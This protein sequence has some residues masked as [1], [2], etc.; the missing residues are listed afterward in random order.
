MCVFVFCFLPIDNNLTWADVLNQ[1]AKLTIGQGIDAIEV[2]YSTDGAEETSYEWYGTLNIISRGNVLATDS[3]MQL[4]I[5]GA[6][7]QIPSNELV[8]FYSAGFNRLD[9]VAHY[10]MAQN[11]QQFTIVDVLETYDILARSTFSQDIVLEELDSVHKETV[12]QSIMSFSLSYG[13]ASIESIYDL[14]T[15]DIDA[16]LQDAL[17]VSHLRMLSQ[18]TRSIPTVLSLYSES[19]KFYSHKINEIL[20]NPKSTEL[21]I[22]ESFANLHHSRNKVFEHKNDKFFIF[23]RPGNP[24]NYFYQIYWQHQGH[25]YLFFEVQESSKGVAVIR[26]IKQLENGNLVFALCIEAC[27][28]LAEYKTV[29]FDWRPPTSH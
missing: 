22:E 27:D 12:Q 16:L 8:V 10:A 1:K 17:R 18:Q 21:L 15:C 28:W 11:G 26:D 9:T 7:R 3:G 13:K 25:W 4:N 24:Y 19:G 14:P 29:T 5:E 6:C 23:D 20:A 2:V